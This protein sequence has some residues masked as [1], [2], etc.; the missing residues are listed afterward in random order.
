MSLPLSKPQPK[1]IVGAIP[2]LLCLAGTKDGTHPSRFG[3]YLFFFFPNI[4][5]KF[6]DLITLHLLIIFIKNFA[7]KFVRIVVITTCVVN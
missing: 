5:L 7:H 2:L 4:V 3:K 6:T 1:H